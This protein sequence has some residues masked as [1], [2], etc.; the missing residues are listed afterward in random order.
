MESQTSE[1]LY[2]ADAQVSQLAPDN[3]LAKLYV[4]FQLGY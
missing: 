1:L 3:D 4:L 2:E